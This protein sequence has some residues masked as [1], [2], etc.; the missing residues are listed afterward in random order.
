[1]PNCTEPPQEGRKALDEWM[2]SNGWG[3]GVNNS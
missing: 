2:A 3:S 1:M